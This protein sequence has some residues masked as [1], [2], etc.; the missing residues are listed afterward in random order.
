MR[1][2]AQLCLGWSLL[3][4]IGMLRLCRSLKGLPRCSGGLGDCWLMASISSPS[5]T[6][7]T[8]SILLK[9]SANSSIVLNLYESTAFVAVVLILLSFLWTCWPILTCQQVWL[10][11][12][13]SFE[14]Y[15]RRKRSQSADC[16]W[17]AQKFLAY[18]GCVLFWCKDIRRGD[19]R[20]TSSGK[21]KTSLRSWPVHL[22]RMASM[23]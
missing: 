16:I 4:C 14:V 10:S 17:R 2:S 13:S 7:F 11:S 21:R 5:L 12:L 20:K 6:S 22:R 15:F 3:C 23:S 18:H 8:L 9:E 19:L 1:S